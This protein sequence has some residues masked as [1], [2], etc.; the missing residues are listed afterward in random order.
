MSFIHRRHIHHIEIQH[1]LDWS[2][3]IGESRWFNKLQELVGHYHSHLI[4]ANL[5]AVLEHVCDKK[6]E[7]AVDFNVGIWLG[8]GLR[9]EV[10]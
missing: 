10:V 6:G 8:G 2:K 3:L 4:S 7:L 9:A 1:G 5:L